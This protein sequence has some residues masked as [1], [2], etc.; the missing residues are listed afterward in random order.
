MTIKHLFGFVLRES[1]KRAPEL[2]AL[3]N[4][5]VIIDGTIVLKD[6]T[7]FG[8]KACEIENNDDRNKISDLSESCF[9]IRRNLHPSV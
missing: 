8:S 4:V 7:T 6:E 2:I 5:V 9:L 1:P 3:V